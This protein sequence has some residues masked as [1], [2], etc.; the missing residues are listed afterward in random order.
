MREPILEPLLRKLRIRRVLPSI[1]RHYNC[2]LLDIGCGWDARLLR[3]VEPYIAFGTGV[4]FKVPEMIEGKLRTENL[5]LLDSLPYVDKSFDL[6]TMLAVLEHLENP[7]AILTEIRRVL[8]PAGELV[9]TVPSRAARPV[10][11]F[12][13]FRLGVI[14]YEEVADHKAYY[15]RVSLTNLLEMTGFCVLEHRYFQLGM[16]NFCVALKKDTRC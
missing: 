4:D 14:S 15:D 3:D 2:R 5:T 9:L 10:I 11:E 6:V 12:L 16:N 7:Q 1:R 13:A 8:V